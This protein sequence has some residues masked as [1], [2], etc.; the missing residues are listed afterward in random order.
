[1]TS[2]FQLGELVI[3][4]AGRDNGSFYIVVG[5]LDKQHVTVANGD[6]KRIEYPKR[7]NVKHL[8]STGVFLE[9]LSIWLESGKRIRNEDIK[10]VLKDYENEE[11]N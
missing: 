11:A 6:K 5:S 10:R 2:R 8:Q 3:S 7:K 1:M 9:E 4:S